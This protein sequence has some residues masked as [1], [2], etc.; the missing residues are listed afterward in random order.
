M[1]HEPIY[2]ELGNSSRSFKEEI[3]EFVH[4]KDKREEGSPYKK[5]ELFW[6]H[7]LFKVICQSVAILALG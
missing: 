2:R 1:I 5:I 3:Q 6:P 7:E 4:L